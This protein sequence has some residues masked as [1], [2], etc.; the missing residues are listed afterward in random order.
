MGEAKAV[1]WV[2]EDG[3]Q[4]F[5]SGFTQKS[6]SWKIA[7]EKRTRQLHERKVSDS[8]EGNSPTTRKA[9]LVTQAGTRVFWH[10]P[11]ADE[12]RRVVIEGR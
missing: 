11:C 12:R 6:V 1:V 7:T 2:E 4:A 3:E 8:S 10:I 5:E 9:L